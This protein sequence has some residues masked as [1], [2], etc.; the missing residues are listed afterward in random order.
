MRYLLFIFLLVAV[1]I[2]EGCTSTPSQAPA[3]VPTQ[4]TAIPTVIETTIVSTTSPVPTEEYGKHPLS[5]SSYGEYCT[6]DQVISG[7]DCPVPPNPFEADGITARQKV[8]CMEGMGDL[9]TCLNNS[10]KWG[11]TRQSMK[12]MW[13]N[14]NSC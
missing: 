10:E 14:T 1:L 13:C 12:F 8:A 3:Q 9:D 2:T 4:I 5:S 7:M 6:A 11:L